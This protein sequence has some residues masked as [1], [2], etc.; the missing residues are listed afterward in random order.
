MKTRL[1]FVA[2][3]SSSSYIVSFK[4][5]INSSKDVL[6]QLD[7]SKTF[8]TLWNEKI[9]KY[10]VASVIFDKISE[11]KNEMLSYK[12]SVEELFTQPQNVIMYLKIPDNKKWDERMDD[13]Y[14]WVFSNYIVKEIEDF[15]KKTP[16]EMESIYEKFNSVMPLD[17]NWEY[18]NDIDLVLKDVL[19][20]LSQYEKHPNTYLLRFG[21][22]TG[23]D[24]ETFL[25]SGFP[26]VINNH[27][28]TI[29]KADSE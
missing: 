18:Q 6:K 8:M 9:Y 26:D 5:P 19:R 11:M 3:S 13:L 16:A 14:R 24:T 7:K 28:V 15:Q 12:T 1:Y 22:D 23:N 2:N 29:H 17:V 4:D 25:R 27:C 10:D 20:C 21:D